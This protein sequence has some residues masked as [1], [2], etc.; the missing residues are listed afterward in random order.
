MLYD[1]TIKEILEKKKRKEEGKFNGVPFCFDRY[2]EYFDSLDKGMY[3]GILGGTGVGKSSLKHHMI[4]SIMDFS[5]KND[6][7]V[8]I[9][10]FSLEDPET[11]VCKKRMIHYLWK[12]HKVDLN[13]KYL[14]LIECLYP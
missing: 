14:N 3:L 11:E 1:R 13:L 8:M 5:T 7:P 4:Y 9:L 10:D 2:S 6:Y 12:R